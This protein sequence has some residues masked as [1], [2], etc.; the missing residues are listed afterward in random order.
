MKPSTSRAI[1]QFFFTCNDYVPPCHSVQAT[2]ESWSV[3]EY[4]PP[5]GD[6]GGLT[7][8]H[9]TWSIVKGTCMENSPLARRQGPLLHAI[10]H[11]PILAFID[12]HHPVHPGNKGQRQGGQSAY[13]LKQIQVHPT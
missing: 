8:L 13:S 1:P 10:T 2:A 6:S 9:L 7:L 4:S 11:H 12:G 3:A 5:T